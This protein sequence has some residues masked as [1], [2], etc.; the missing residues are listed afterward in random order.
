MYV[1]AKEG[2]RIYAH[3]D[4]DSAAKMFGYRLTFD[5]EPQLLHMQN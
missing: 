2:K 1:R 3:Y 4:K 5:G